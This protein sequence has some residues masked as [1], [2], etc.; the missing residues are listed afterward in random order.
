MMKTRLLIALVFGS[1]ALVG[2]S[3]DQEEIQ[4]WMQQESQRIKPHVEPI[5]PPRKFEPEAYVGGNGADPF[6]V[7][8]MIAGTRAGANGSSALLATEMKRRKE[9]L[10][11]YPLDSM[12][13]VGLVIREGQP[14]ALLKVDNLLHYVKVG[15]YL[16]QNFGKITRI[17]ETE[18]DLREIVQD[19]SGEWVESSSSLQLQES[20]K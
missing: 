14:H 19:A 6:S 20:G 13:M 12:K 7:A 4:G 16:G 10:E 18:I 15:D 8:K 11:A 9:P 2:C 3:G 5:H 17:T 1:A